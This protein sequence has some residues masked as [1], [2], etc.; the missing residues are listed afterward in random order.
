MHTLIELISRFRRDERGAFAMLF[1]V[2]SIALIAVSGAAVDFTVLQQARTRAQTVLDAAALALQP[3]I[4]TATTATIQSQAQNLLLN[5]LGDSSTAWQSCATTNNQPPCGTVETPV[6]DTS[7]GQLTLTADLKVPVYFVGLVGIKLMPAQIV[8]V[9]TRKKLNLEVAM[10]LDNS[11]SM[12]YTMGYNKTLSSKDNPT[13]IPDRMTVLKESATCAANILFYGVSD[14]STSTTGLTANANVKI[15]IVPFT[16]EVNVGASN[17]S[18]SWLDRGNAA[19]Y[20][21]AN[22][23]NDDND[24]TAFSGSVD[25]IALFQNI[26]DSKGNALS[27]GG[28]VEARKS[29]Y[30]TDDTPPTTGDTL[31]T[32]FFAVDEPGDAMTTSNGSLQAATSVHGNSYNNSY[33]SDTPSIC[34]QNPKVTWVETKT[35]CTSA[36]SSRTTSS[37]WSKLSCSGTTTESYT[38]VDQNGTTTNP[39]SLPSTIYN[40]N[41]DGGVPNSP[42]S[43][44]Y[45]NTGSSGSGSSK[46]YTNTRTRIYYYLPDRVLQERLCKYG[47]SANKVSMATQP[48]SSSVFGPNGDCPAASVLPLTTTPGDVI[49][50]INN[51][52]ANGGTNITEGSVWGW[53]VLSPN[54][55][56]DSKGAAYS[57]STSKVLI[58]MTDG[59]NTIYPGTNMNYATFYSAYAYPYNQRLV[60]PASSDASTLEAVMNQRL[61]NSD[62]ISNVCSNAKAAGITVYTIGVDVDDSD[63]DPDVAAANK[64]LLT[65]CAT[66]SSY[67][68]FPNS[69]DDLENAFVN[70][71]QQLAALRIAQ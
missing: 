36:V 56:F 33:I 3:T 2:M 46:T 34:K 53:H 19:S 65:D 45:A 13:N 50:A 28:C 40:N 23:D 35:K 25:R 67:A 42:D 4:Y 39:S 12:A 20:T 69:V 14:C 32:P 58:I 60:S 54:S 44:T 18:A 47:T 71:A 17:S 52:S 61:Q 55:P 37:S 57:N 59:E 64:Q 8:S 49:T 9:A 29:P 6:V 26:K 48:V 5:Q 21:S 43:E 11:G 68:Y 16:Q 1:A 10:V 7:L 70:I 41:N 30:D 15:G 51:M 66:Q 38:E 27:W 63:N 62:G 31:Y 24:T 22:F